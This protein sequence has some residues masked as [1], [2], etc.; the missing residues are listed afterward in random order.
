[1]AINGITGNI[2]NIPLL[3]N[4]NNLQKIRKD[5]DVLK[6]ALQK[7]NI[8]NAQKAFAVAQ[9]DIN[10][11]NN[12]NNIANGQMQ[13]NGQNNQT[14][15]A[16]KTLAQALQNGNIANA[17][18]AFAIFEQGQRVQAAGILQNGNNK[19]AVQANNNLQQNNNLINLA[20]DLAVANNNTIQ[21]NANNTADAV[22]NK[23][24]P[25]I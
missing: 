3:P 9:E 2:N 8:G 12:K 19:A 17:Q 16:F 11:I 7:G 10:N 13:A 1:M 25:R 21:N 4:I 15:N 22:F 23:N 20:R 18:K 24:W 6:Q 5:F 14:V